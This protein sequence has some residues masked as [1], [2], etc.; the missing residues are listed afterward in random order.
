LESTIAT[1][2]LNHKYYLAALLASMN[3]IWE[4]LRLA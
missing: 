4:I 1:E 2:S 3:M